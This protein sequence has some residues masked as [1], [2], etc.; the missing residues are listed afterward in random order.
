MFGEKDE[1]NFKDKDSQTLIEQDASFEGKL[2][3]A[4][5]VEIKG[6]FKGQVFS[7]GTLIVS[8]SAQVEAQ[9]DVDTIIIRGQ[10]EG[11]IHAKRL[12]E[13]HPPAVVRG[14]IRSPGLVISE[15]ALFEGQCSMGKS[16]DSTQAQPEPAPVLELTG[17]GDEQAML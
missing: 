12:I 9:I 17:T 11:Q 10:V 16:T 7:E 1:D 14:E 6:K 4:G 5:T 8:E 13:I 2:T 15:G 3:F